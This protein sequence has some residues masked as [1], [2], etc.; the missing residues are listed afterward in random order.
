MA[1]NPAYQD[2]ANQREEMNKFKKYALYLIATLLL[3]V[4]G[5]GLGHLIAPAIVKSD[6]SVTTPIDSIRK[7]N[8]KPSSWTLIKTDQM[9]GSNTEHYLDLN[10]IKKF[11]NGGS[12]PYAITYEKNSQLMI[13]EID[14]IYKR[15]KTIATSESIIKLPIS[16]L[17]ITN[18]QPNTNW[19]LIPFEDKLSN[20]MFKYICNK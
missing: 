10:N 18:N 12:I 7:N 20:S 1:A 4:I 9:L 16:E 13:I 6:S 5:R 19:S 2:M 3:A 11:D 8:Q 17:Q 14:C 15:A